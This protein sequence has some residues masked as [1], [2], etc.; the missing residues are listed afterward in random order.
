MIEII[1]VYNAKS[2][3]VNKLIDFAHKIISPSTYSCSLCTLTHN[4]FGPRDDWKAFLNNPSYSIQ[5]FYKNEFEEKF[6]KSFDYPVILKREGSEF[7]IIFGKDKIAE[8]NSLSD[9][10]VSVTNKIQEQLT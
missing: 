2:D 8:M 10:L 7:E 1:F 5:V 6:K 9:L 4:D 3:S